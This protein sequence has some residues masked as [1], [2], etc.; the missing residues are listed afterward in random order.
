MASVQAG[1]ALVLSRLRLLLGHQAAGLSPPVTRR[2]TSVRTAAPASR[3][4]PSRGCHRAVAGRPRRAPHFLLGVARD[5]PRAWRAFLVLSSRTPVSAHAAPYGLAVR[6]E[7]VG[8]RVGQAGGVAGLLGRLL[9]MRCS[10]KMNRR[11]AVVLPGPE[12][13]LRSL[14]WCRGWGRRRPGRPRCPRTRV[15]PRSPHR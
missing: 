11:G 2:A 1:V 8:V 5:P 4:A 7:G 10:G 6:L 12:R 3:I 14:G 13:P 9:G 15:G